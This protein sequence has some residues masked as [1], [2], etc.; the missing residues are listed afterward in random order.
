MFSSD[1][2]YLNVAG[3]FKVRETAADLAVA[4]AL[5]S[6]KKENLYHPG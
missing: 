4:L 5:V 1:D 2:V 6:M 3:G